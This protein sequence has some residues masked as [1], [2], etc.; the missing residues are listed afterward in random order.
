[1]AKPESRTQDASTPVVWLLTD[2]KPGHR[3]QLKGL[4]NRLRVLT[5]ASTYWVDASAMKIPLWRALLGA[6]PQMETS[7]P[8]PDL[9]IAA[10]SGTHR[11]LLALRKLR[12]TRT[13]VIMKP[14]FPLSLV[15]GAL[16]PA[17]DRVHPGP[18]V[19]LT[20]G[21]LNT[22]TPLARI[23]EK[24]EAL[25]LI[26]GP[27]PH[28]DWDDDVVLG[29]VSHLIGHYP[30]W[31]WTISTSRRT[32]E[33]MQERLDEMAGLR[34]T[35]VHPD[36][37][38]ED[39][40]SHQL[41]ASR[42]VWVTPDSMSMVCEAATSGVPTGLFELPARSGSRVVEG[43]ER[44]VRSGYVARWTDHA[45]VMAGR[46][47]HDRSLWEANRAARWVIE[48]GLLTK[49]QKTSQRLHKGSQP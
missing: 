47:D 17:H 14:A 10:G 38:H 29:Q 7:L 45:S 48:K 5:G 6:P 44:L 18:R 9:V 49:S 35:V 40:L 28:F 21:V 13:L 43:V 22:I 32:P 11:L 36:Q 8:R 15:N 24:R 30:D 41:S 4:G 39:W 2:S 26:G 20:E 25:L 34:I 27:S 23:T 12:G 42:A 33:P 1:M 3:N 31:R 19:L 16:I 46:T 37:T